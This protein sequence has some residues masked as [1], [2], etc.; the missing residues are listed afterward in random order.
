MIIGVAGKARAGKDTVSEMIQMLSYDH[1]PSEFHKY[2]FAR[3]LKE[4]CRVIFGWDDRHLY[5]DLKEEIDPLFGVTPRYAMQTL[6]TEW[7]RDLI[8]KD[9]WV[10]RAEREHQNRGNIVVSDVRF[11]NECHWVQNAGGVIINVYRPEADEISGVSEHA[12]EQGVSHMLRTNVDYV[13]VNDSTIDQLFD[14]VRVIFKDIMT[15]RKK[16]K[17]NGSV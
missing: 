4:A 11:E 10:L 3:P 17:K 12:S 13:I 8:N 14:T 5:G 7:G 15:L 1:G 9:T 16:E 6:G 2:E